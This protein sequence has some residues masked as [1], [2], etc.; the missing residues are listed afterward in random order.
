MNDLRIPPRNPRT[1]TGRFV[2]PTGC[3]CSTCAPPLPWR[4]LAIIGAVL[5]ASLALSLSGC[6]TFRSDVTQASQQC[7]LSQHV[8]DAGIKLAPY[9]AKAVA[10]LADGQASTIEACESIVGA[11]VVATAVSNAPEEVTDILRCAAALVAD[12]AKGKAI[13]VSRTAD[14]GK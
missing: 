7:S 1:P 3:N 8:K 6:A 2:I 14:A 10:C 11:D 13:S 4:K 12:A 5:V 9:E